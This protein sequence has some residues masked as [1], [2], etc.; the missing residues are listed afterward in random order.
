MV[1]G[2]GAWFVCV[3]ISYTGGEGQ[4]GCNFLMTNYIVGCVRA[5]DILRRMPVPDTEV[6]LPS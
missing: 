5:G 4:L 3:R 1:S 6:P 2:E